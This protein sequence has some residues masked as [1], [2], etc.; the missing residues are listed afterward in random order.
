MR[1][2]IQ[3]SAGGLDVNASISF[4]FTQLSSALGGAAGHRGDVAQVVR[5][6]PA[7]DAQQAEVVRRA[8]LSSIRSALGNKID[9]KA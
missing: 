6:A 7:A 3:H 1:R 9:G 8:L 5:L 4:F 2:H